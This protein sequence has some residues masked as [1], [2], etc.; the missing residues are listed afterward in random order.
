ER[1][2]VDPPYAYLVTDI[3]TD[4]IARSLL[5]GINNP[6][7]LPDRPV[8]AKTGTTDDNRDNWT[9]G[10]PP[11]L[12]TAVWVGTTDNTKMN[13]LALGLSNAAPL[14]HSVM[15][16]YHTGRPVQRFVRPPG[17]VTAEVCTASGLLASPSCGQRRQEVFVAGKLPARQ[18]D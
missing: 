10:F 4:N 18:R 8:G 15:V 6:L 16:T 2:V 3:V 12:V 1:Q 13:S 7:T 9:V 11:D 17:V 14:W 5:Y